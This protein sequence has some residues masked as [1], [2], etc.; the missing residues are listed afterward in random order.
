MSVFLVLSSL[1]VLFYAL[2]LVALYRDSRSRRRNRVE[3]FEELE[4]GEGVRL[5]NAGKKI[6]ANRP[7]SF[8]VSGHPV[9]KMEW[10]PETRS[11]ITR[12]RSS[13]AAMI[14]WDRVR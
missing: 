6:L 12:N 5:T 13:A 8:G 1:S 3:W 14:G 2:L 7:S 9:T 10:K 11:R 4:F